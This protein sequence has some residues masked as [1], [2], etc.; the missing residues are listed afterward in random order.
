MFDRVAGR[1]DAAQLGDDGGP[2]PSLARARRR[3]GRAR[4][5]RL[6]ARRLLRH[7]RPRA[8][9]RRAGRPRRQRRRLRLLRADARPGPREGARRGAPT[10]VR[11]EW[12]DALSLPYDAGRFDAVTV[13]FGVRNLADLDRG[14]REMARVLRPGGRLVVLEITQPTRPPLSTFFSLWFDRLVP[15]LGSFSDDA[16]PTPTC[17][18]RCAASPTRAPGGEDG[19]RAGFERIRYTV[20]AGGI[21][22]IHS[23]V[24]RVTRRSAVPPP[25]TAVLD[26]SSRWL[27]ARLG[28]G[29]GA[30]AGAGRRP[31]RAA[32]RR[33]RRDAGGRRQAP[34]AAARPAL[35]RRRRRARRRCAPAPR[36]SSSTWRP[37]STTTSSTTRR[38]AAASPPSPPPRAASARSAPATCSSRAPSRSSPT[39]A[40]R[41]AIAAA[42]RGL[43]R[44]RPGRA[45]PAPGRLRHRGLRAAL[46]GSLP[47]ED[48]DA[49]RVR[50]PARPRRRRRWAPSAPRSGSPSSCSTTCSTS[51]ARRSGPARRAAPTCSTAP[52][53]CR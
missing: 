4:P 32:R 41:R 8:G 38:C 24:A 35:R 19:P 45:R 22:A 21:I 25:V 50:L 43:G 31:R 37:S 16:R 1:Y 13:G 46:P 6:R 30:A 28:R 44:A 2:A 47:A 12:A 39:P 49:V 9:A 26:A 17:P 5:R 48:R 34:A 14:L 18:N 51:P 10:G 27:P 40:T 36:S 29:R 42:R 23:G 33:R 11:F 52:S 53:P 7:R 3:P 15:L 20:L